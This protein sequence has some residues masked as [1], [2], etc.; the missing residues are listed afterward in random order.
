[1][2]SINGLPQARGGR[3]RE[4]YIINPQ[5]GP[6]RHLRKARYAR[7]RGARFHSAAHQWAAQWSAC[8]GRLR[9]KKTPPRAALGDGCEAGLGNELDLPTKAKMQADRIRMQADR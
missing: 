4:R 2:P 7:P 3:A 8:N 6:A 9:K 5:R 1:M